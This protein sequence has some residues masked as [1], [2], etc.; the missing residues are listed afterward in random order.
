MKA[1]KEYMSLG[2]CNVLKLKQSYMEQCQDKKFLEYVSLLPIEEDLLISYTSTLKDACEE[3]YACQS[4]SSYLECK[5][6]VKGYQLTPQKEGQVINFSYVACP[7]E[8]KRLQ[9]TAFQKYVSFY[10]VPTEVKKAS[11]KSIYKDDNKRRPIIQYFTQ[12]MKA[13]DTKEPVKGLYLHGSFGSGKTYLIAALFNEVAKKNVRSAIVYFP[14]FLRHLKSSFHDDF[15]E[16]FNYI[17]KVPLLLLDDIG[18]ENLTSWS[19]DEILGP[20]LQYRMEEHLQTFFTSNLT[21]EELESHLSV[22]ANGV[23]KVKSRRIIERIKQLTCDI[24]LS[25]QNRRE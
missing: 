11:F 16:K 1:V 8:K 18:A 2:K 14:E 24:E 15:E 21:L 17:K 9:E 13:L 5:N 12:F 19:R 4:C 3:F 22:T 20:I 6:K 25:S 23:D 7:Y 10:H